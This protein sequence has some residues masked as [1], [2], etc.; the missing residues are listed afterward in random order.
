LTEN[1]QRDGVPNLCRGQ[2]ILAEPAGEIA[3]A[4]RDVE[5]DSLLKML[6]SA[7]KIAEMKAGDAGNAVCD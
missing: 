7:G 4:C 6:M 2:R 5:L 1:P 3:M